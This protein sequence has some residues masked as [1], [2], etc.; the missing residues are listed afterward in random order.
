MEHFADMSILGAIGLHGWQQEA[1]WLT[2][3]PQKMH[4]FRESTHEDELY[5][6]Y[7]IGRNNGLEIRNLENDEKYGLMSG[8]TITENEDNKRFWLPR[9]FS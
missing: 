5:L 2:G 9:D 4:P 7:R 1:W 8:I 3:L 6:Y